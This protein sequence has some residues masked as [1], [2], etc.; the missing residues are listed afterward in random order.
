MGWQTLSSQRS[1]SACKN[2]RTTKKSRKIRIWLWIASTRS[3]RGHKLGTNMGKLEM[4]SNK[5]TST[6]GHRGRKYMLERGRL[7]RSRRMTAGQMHEPIKFINKVPFEA[8]L[9][10]KLWQL[11]T[12]RVAVRF[13]CEHRQVVTTYL[14][15][16]KLTPA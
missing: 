13:V 8:V 11:C 16:S 14:Q 15:L 10:N 6:N 1:C 7:G 2:V 5:L 9:G 4:P 12:E 3:S